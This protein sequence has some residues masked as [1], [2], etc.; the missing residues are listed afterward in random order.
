MRI[1]ICAKTA[2]IENAD[3]PVVEF[4]HNYDIEADELDLPVQHD[5]ERNADYVSIP[6]ANVSAW[7]IQR[8]PSETE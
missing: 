4:I 3:D 2:Y 8:P 7:T 6:I 5:E 1:F